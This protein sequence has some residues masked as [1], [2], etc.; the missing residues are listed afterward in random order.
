MPG[1][2]TGEATGPEQIR[3]AFDLML[4]AFARDRRHVVAK[5]E[6]G[7]AGDSAG[8]L[9]VMTAQDPATNGTA[10]TPTFTDRFARDGDRRVFHRR[11]PAADPNVQPI[12][13]GLMGRQAA[14]RRTAPCRR[15]PAIG[16]AGRRSFGSSISPG[17]PP[18]RMRF[19]FASGQARST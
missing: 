10:G 16:S 4:T 6:A 18:A 2:D 15:F 7:I 1:Q 19:W 8:M 3:A 14:W 5:R 17:P 9:S 11:T 13:D 12:I